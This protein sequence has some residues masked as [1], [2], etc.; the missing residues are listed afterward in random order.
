M[1]I[2]MLH[3]DTRHAVAGAAGM[4]RWTADALARRGHEVALAGTAAPVPGSPVRHLGPLPTSPD[5]LV[6]RTG[7][8]PDVVHV[9]DLADP[10]AGWCGLDLAS[11][12]GCAI[13]VTPATHP[14]LWTD[15]AG[16][17][18]L[19]RLA[20]VVLVLTPAEGDALAA[21]GIAPERLA[22]LG[23]GPQLDGQPAPAAFR[24]AHGIEGPLVLFLG[25]RLP[26]KG[27]QHLLVAAPTILAHHPTA[28]IVIAGPA[29]DPDSVAATRAA[30]VVDVGELDD[31]TKHSALAAA[32]LLCLPT[33]ADAF[34]LVFVEAWWCG[35]P[36]VSGPFAGVHDVVRDGV[37][38][39]VAPAEPHAVA[40]AVSGLLADPR[41]RRAMGRAGRQRAEQQFSW[42]A[43][44]TGAE[45]AYR[46]ARLTS[47]AT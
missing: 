38:G 21:H 47:I 41:R 1:R 4:A 31:A 27:Y 10:A 15:H 20:D 23:Q 5:G 25:R 6:A 9:T 33:V 46:A 7:W 40:C 37:D 12:L 19:A 3:H 18:D 43:V 34:P 8:V 22:P 24:A 39:L 45:A 44:A 26:S 16:G 13:A 42:D 17:L 2:V 29:S 11:R 35:T 32:D 36:V 30:P 28:T 14:A